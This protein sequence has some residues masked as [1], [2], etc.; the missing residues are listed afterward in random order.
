MELGDGV[1]GVHTLIKDEVRTRRETT[2]Y[3]FICEGVNYGQWF[4]QDQGVCEWRVGQHAAPVK[5]QDDGIHLR[6]GNVD[7]KKLLFDHPVQVVCF[8]D[9]VPGVHHPV[10]QSST[11]E[12]VLW[13]SRGRI[14]TQ[15]VTGWVIRREIVR[16]NEVGGVTNGMFRVGVATQRKCLKWRWKPKER[17]VP[18]V[19]L[20]VLDPCQSGR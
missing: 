7:I 12:S 13:I 9:T 6:L 16:H 8:V 5:K 15:E 2:R 18:N 14:R 19:L 11:V 10:W 17:F 3:G 20:Q 1:A 4:L